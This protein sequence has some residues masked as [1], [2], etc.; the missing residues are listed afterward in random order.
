VRPAVDW[1][2]RLYQSANRLA[3]F[4]FLREIG[5]VDVF[6]ANVYFTGDPHSPTTGQEWDK[7]IRAVSQELGIAGP[8]PCSVSV[9][10]EAVR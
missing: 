6:L 7:G 1:L 5:K 2:G 4:H 9:F 8:V 10:R 3:C